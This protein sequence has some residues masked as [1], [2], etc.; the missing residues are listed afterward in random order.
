MEMNLRPVFRA[1]GIVFRDIMWKIFTLDGFES[2]IAMRVFVV[3][4]SGSGANQLQEALGVLC[5]P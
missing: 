2:E 1:T 5:D 4:Q 3:I